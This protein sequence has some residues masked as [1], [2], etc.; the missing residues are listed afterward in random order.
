MKKSKT[1]HFLEG[2]S[3]GQGLIEYALIIILIAIVTILVL[4]LTGVSINAVYCQ[5]MNDLNLEA[6]VCS[7]CNTG[8]ASE[9]DLAG[10]EGEG[11][12]NIQL[13]DGRACF[14]GT[15][16][17]YGSHH[18][19]C[20][21]SLGSND[22]TL[23]LE[24]LNMQYDRGYPYWLDG[25]HVGFREQDER[26]GYEFYYFAR[27]N[28]IYLVKEVNGR[29]IVL[30]YDFVSNDWRHGTYD[31]QIQV[32]GDTFTVL[33]DDTPVLSASDNTYTEGD[34][35]FSG[36]MFSSACVSGISTDTP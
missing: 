18:N 35:G 23:T 6:A 21:R 20:S 31:L 34:I 8:F 26:N 12:N 16:G 24:D 25:Y 28:L 32:Q 2:K 5:A 7:A 13:G 4:S 3:R 10:W 9:D 11:G 29:K 36:R 1:R 27:Y 30:D 17:L 14:G 15:G 19:P 33:K 22:F